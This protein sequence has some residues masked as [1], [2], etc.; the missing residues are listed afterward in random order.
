MRVAGLRAEPLMANRMSGKIIGKTI[1]A[2]WRVVRTTAR[3]ATA[4]VC[5]SSPAPWV[6]PLSGRG[7]GVSATSTATSPPAPAGGLDRRLGDRAV[8]GTLELPAGLG[9]E[10][11]VER[12]LMELQGLEPQVGAVEES[13]DLGQLALAAGEL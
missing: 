2:R 8:T 7:G 13:H 9:Q 12:G 11:V 3:R 1:S 6:A 5:S 4:N 10:H